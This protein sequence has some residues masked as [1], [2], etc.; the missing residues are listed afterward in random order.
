MSAEHLAQMFG[1]A[2][3]ETPKAEPKKPEVPKIEP[4]TEKKAEKKEKS[5]SEKQK[6][7]KTDK[8]HSKVAKIP[9]FD[10]FVQHC[11]DNSKRRT[12]GMLAKSFIS[13]KRPI[14]ATVLRVLEVLRTYS[15]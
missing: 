7:E 8:K 10:E 2:E 9:S 13:K 1:E 5:S 6:R 4:K 15:R 3:K 11:M 14:D 12:C